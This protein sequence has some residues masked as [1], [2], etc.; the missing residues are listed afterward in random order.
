MTQSVR[1]L[2]TGPDWR[3]SDIVCTAGPGDRRFEE[4]HPGFCIA[5]VTR[6]TFQ[7]RTSQGAAT[8]APGAVLLGNPGMCFECGHDHSRGDRCLSIHYEPA[9]LASVPGATRF[10]AARLP[11]LPALAQ[12]AAAADLAMTSTDAPDLEEFALALAGRVVGLLH[13]ADPTGHAPSSRDERRITAAIHRIETAP[14]QPL[15]LESLA[16]EAAMSR[17]HFLRTFRRL[18]GVTPHQFVLRTRLHRAAVA[19]AMTDLPVLEVALQ[20]G[21][22]DL[23][24]FNRRFRGTMGVAPTAYRR[25]R[26]HADR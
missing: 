26:R 23:S 21:F 5:V 16:Q 9:L 6:G 1:T 22:D 7:Y 4:Q 18:V 12:M 17:F 25:G 3:V 15:S 11:P 14:D 8:L 13:G 2:A 24:T 10:T 19:L 20:A